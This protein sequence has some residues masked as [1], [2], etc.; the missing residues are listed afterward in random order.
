M[1]KRIKRWIIWLM[2][3]GPIKRKITLWVYGRLVKQMAKLEEAEAELMQSSRTIEDQFMV[4]KYYK[5]RKTEVLNRLS[6][7]RE[8]QR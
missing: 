2:V 1:R 7:L 5:D 8:V 6:D 3:M 4:Q